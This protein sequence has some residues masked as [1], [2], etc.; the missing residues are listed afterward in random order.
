MK[1]LEVFRRKQKLDNLF[2]QIKAF[3][4]DEELIAHWSRYLCV[5]VCGFLETAMF[6]IYYEFAR[7]KSHGF[8][9]NYVQRQLRRFQN[10]K[11]EK[12]VS[13]AGAFNEIWRDELKQVTDGELK[14][15]VD[16]IV[17][18]RNNIAH[19]RNSDITFGRME[20]YYRKA[21]K[22]IDLVENLCYQR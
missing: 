19:G 9:A 4:G 6:E 10:P 2:K 16:S 8:I 17:N 11:M 12:I 14:D 21:V 3:Q 15:A 5:L 18:N 13:L 1:Q 7:N 22:V 20:E